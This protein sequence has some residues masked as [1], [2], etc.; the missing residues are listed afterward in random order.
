MCTAYA[1]AA[2]WLPAPSVGASSG[3]IAPASSSQL[4]ITARSGR[5]DSAHAATWSSVAEKSIGVSI[6]LPT[7]A[8]PNAVS[9]RIATSTSRISAGSVVVGT[10]SRSA[11]IHGPTQSRSSTAPASRPSSE[12]SAVDSACA[13]SAGTCSYAMSWNISAWL[14][15]V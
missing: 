5:L 6:R 7:A 9:S 11:S 8:C 10:A 2:V 3:L 1:S 4:H 14:L 15:R 12:K 13:L